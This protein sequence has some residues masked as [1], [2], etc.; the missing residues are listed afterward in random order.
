MKPKFV[1]ILI[2]FVLISCIF[3]YINSANQIK[4]SQIIEMDLYVKNSSTGINL[5]TD[6]VHFGTLNPAEASR[7]TREVTISHVHSRSCDVRIVSAGELSKW[8]SL[9]DDRFVLNEGANKSI[10]VTLNLPSDAEYGY[11]G[12]MLIANLRC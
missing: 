2:V 5:D 1:L 9:S 6:A 12:G 10:Q 4:D 8:V 3:W 7:A 11:Y